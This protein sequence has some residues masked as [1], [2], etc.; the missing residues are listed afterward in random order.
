MTRSST[1]HVVGLLRNEP[2]SP[3]QVETGSLYPTLHRREVK[4]W[5]ADSWKRSDQ[6]KRAVDDELTPAKK[7]QFSAERSK[8]DNCHGPCSWC[9]NRPKGVSVDR[10]RWIFSPPGL[11][12]RWPWALALP[13]HG[14]GWLL[15][16]FVRLTMMR[17][18]H[19][20]SPPDFETLRSEARS[21]DGMAAYS[22]VEYRLAGSRESR[23]FLCARVSPELFSVLGVA[24][25]IKDD[26]P[27]SGVVVLSHHL[28]SAF[29]A[30]R[31]SLPSIAFGEGLYAYQRMF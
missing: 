22:N 15:L 21:F 17:G 25:A 27:D 19:G 26:R 12:A 30:T 9:W 6:G 29:A 13:Y 31:Q 11:W 3:S 18:R 28:W 5:I 14:P 24:P 10:R 20:V 4:S 23:R 1:Q 7:K 8:W 2:P 16:I